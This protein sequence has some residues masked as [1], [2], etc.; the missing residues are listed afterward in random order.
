MEL[1]DYQEKLMPAL[2][3]LVTDPA[4]RLAIMALSTGVGKTYMSLEL[5]R[6]TNSSFGILAPKPTL[7]SWKK[8]AEVAG[9]APKFLWNPEAVRTGNKNQLVKKISNSNYDWIGL[10][11]GD[12]VIIDEVHRYGSPDS[13][14]AFMAACLAKKNIR[15]VALSATLSSSPLRLRF[16]LNHARQVPWNSFYAWCKSKGCARS[17]IIQGSPWMPPPPRLC[18]QVMGEVHDM[19]FPAFGVK[20]DS[21]D[22]EGFP[23]VQNI[24]DLVTPSEAARKAINAGYA[25][26]SDAIRHPEKAQNQ[27]VESLRAR[28]QVEH[29][30]VHIF[31]ELIQDALEDGLSVFVAVNFTAPLFELAQAFSADKPALVY[32]SDPNGRQQTTEER[33]EAIRRFQANETKLIFGTIAAGST[34]ISLGDVTGDAPRIAF[35]SI[36][37]SPVELHQAMG[38][39]HRADSKT[40]SIN[41]IILVE[42]VPIEHKIHRLLMNKM[43]AMSE[44]QGDAFEK[45]FSEG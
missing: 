22:I 44:L 11:E 16:L 45:I 26:L 29:A 33:D 40:P 38:R 10:N 35:L 24:I 4:K 19:L 5:M 18:K 39:I 2:K 30:K 15:V 3:E 6:R 42:G 21:K 23:R 28:Q 41:R 27:L 17:T 14:M 13:Q 37:L 34:G 7:Y 31:K 1:Y 8:S 9:V 25:M 36:P 20:L 32:G 12:V 43:H